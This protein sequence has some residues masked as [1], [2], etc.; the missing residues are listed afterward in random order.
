MTPIIKHNTDPRT[1]A[2][3]TWLKR[4]TDTHQLDLQSISPASSDASFR[5]YFRITSAKH[6]TVIAMDAPPEQENSQPFVDVTRLL[7]QVNLNVPDILAQDLDQGFLLL[8]DLGT[9]TYFQAVQRPLDDATLQKLYRDAIA[10]LVTLQT[11]NTVTLP[12]YDEGCLL[13]ELS[14]F[15]EWYARVHRQITLDTEDESRLAQAFA[16]LAS[17]NARAG[18]VFVHRDFHSPNLIVHDG[19]TADFNPGIIDYQDAVAG[20]ITYDIASLVMDARTTWE[21]PQQLDWAI[22]YWEAARAA[23]LPVD[24]DFAD[25]HTAYEWMSLQR[26]LRVLGVFARLSHRDDKHHYLDH[27]P[28]VNA[29]VRQVA[30]RYGVF[31]P[32]LRVL[33]KIDNIQVTSGYTF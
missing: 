22:R 6:G 5:R 14:L 7:Q 32:L 10:A 29:Y 19:L 18:T 8:T 20:P 16:M 11:A 30:T 15:T 21:E 2:L 17:H 25:F 12:R 1:H 23:D 27:I 26:N 3:D 31:R 33:D 24:T 4:L 28:R 13:D 9:Q